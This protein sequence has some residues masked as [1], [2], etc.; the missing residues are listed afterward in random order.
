VFV[1]DEVCVVWADLLEKP[2]EVFCRRPRLTLVIAC[3]GRGARHAGAA[4][5]TVIAVGRGSLKALVAPFLAPL[6]LS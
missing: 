5:L 4:R 6:T 3:G 2:F 1:P